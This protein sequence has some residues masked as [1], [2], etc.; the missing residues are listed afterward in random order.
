MLLATG[1]VAGAVLVGVLN[2]NEPTNVSDRKLPLVLRGVQALGTLHTARHT[3]ENVF[4]YSTSR[5]PLQ[6]VA[7]VPGG[8]EL[9]RTGTRNVVLVS[10]TG[11]I[12]AGVDLARATVERS[13]DTVTVRLP[14]PQLFEPK[15]DAK[16]HWQKSAVFWRDDNIALKAVRDAEDRIKEA[17]LRQ[18]ILE[19]AADVAG[20]RVKSLA[21]DMGMD[22]SVAF[23]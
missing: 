2:R 11:E 19:T 23:G 20:K 1:G 14:K 18:H 12:E 13:G 7:M 6:W 5:Q 16:V 17:S 15:V 9:V 8:A 22:V 10:A 3:Y 4:E 21:R